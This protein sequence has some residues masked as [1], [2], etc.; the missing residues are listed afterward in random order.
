MSYIISSQT[1]LCQKQE[2]RSVVQDIQLT[3]PEDS[4]RKAIV[5]AF[6]NSTSLNVTV[7]ALGDVYT[8]MNLN[9]GNMTVPDN[10]NLY[11]AYEDENG[12]VN[13]VNDENDSPLQ[14]TKDTDLSQLINTK[15]Q[16]LIFV[17]QMTG[18]Q[19]QN[20]DTQVVDEFVS[21]VAEFLTLELCGMLMQT[22]CLLFLCCKKLTSTS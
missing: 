8:V 1:E 5:D 11:L 15:V 10:W 17:L 3:A 18:T 14:V 7:F 21:T 22:F 9:F 12:V 6:G 19:E 20:N 13:V 4:V 16:S 2:I